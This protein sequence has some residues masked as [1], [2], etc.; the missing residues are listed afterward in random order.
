MPPAGRL[1]GARSIHEYRCQSMRRPHL[2][3]NQRR[4]RETE[5]DALL[6]LRLPWA[7]QKLGAHRWR[8]FLGVFSDGRE[9]TSVLPK[10]QRMAEAEWLRRPIRNYLCDIAGAMA[11]RK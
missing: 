5:H 1:P 4:L 2:A 7:L 11:C 8:R 3:A 10:L 6:L 9:C